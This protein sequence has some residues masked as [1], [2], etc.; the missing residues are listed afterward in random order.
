M[1]QIGNPATP[2]PQRHGRGSDDLAAIQAAVHEVYAI[3]SGPQGA[4]RDWDRLRSL[5]VSG[6][7]MIP[8]RRVPAGPV[9]VM[10]IDAYIERVDAVFKTMSFHEIEIAARVEVFGDIAHVLS[11]YESRHNA[12]DPDPF[13]RGVNSIQLLRDAGRWRLVSVLWDVEN[14]E[15]PIPPEYLPAG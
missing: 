11:T 4:P 10:D 1:A 8:Q 2:N 6:A 15:N 3:I 14:D 7:R 13:M 12:D 5:F 9:K